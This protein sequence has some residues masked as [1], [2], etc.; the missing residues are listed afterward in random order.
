MDPKVWV[1][2]LTAFGVVLVAAELFVPGMILGV[3]GTIALMAAVIVAYSALGP[4]IGSVLLA[5]LMLGG[6]VGFMLWLRMF[7]KTYFGKKLSLNANVGGP[8]SFPDF[9][10]LLGVEGI[11]ESTLRPAGLARLAGK[12]VDVVAEGDFVEAGEPVRVVRVEGA[13]VV[14]RRG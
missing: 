1:I 3:A 5:A 7:P 12:R 14:V 11:A 2:G 13:R 4:M 8:G 9:S 10:A 6:I